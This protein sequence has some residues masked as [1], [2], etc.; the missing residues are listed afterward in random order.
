MEPE[1][2]KD[3]NVWN[4]PVREYLEHDHEHVDSQT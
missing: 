2:S 4:Y 3:S 1:G